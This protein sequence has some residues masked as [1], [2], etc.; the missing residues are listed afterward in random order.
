MS[1]VFSFF[2]RRNRYSF[3][4]IENSIGKLVRQ[5]Y[6]IFRYLYLDFITSKKILYFN[7][8]GKEGLCIVLRRLTYPNRLTDLVHMFKRDE[9]TISRIFNYMIKWIYAKHATRL[10]SLE[11]NYLTRAVLQELADVRKLV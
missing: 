3:G 11:Q 1:F 8:L 4:F 2:V 9:G 7:V 6:Q 10:H 5:S